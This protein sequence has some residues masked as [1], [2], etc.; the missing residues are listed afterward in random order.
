MRAVVTGAASGIG[1]ATAQQLAERGFDLV[2]VDRNA[3][4]L[5]ETAGGFSAIQHRLECV[6]LSSLGAVRDLAARLAPYPVDVLINNA[7]VLVERREQTVDGFELTF[8]VNTLAPFLLTRL[9]WP[10][11]VASGDGRVINVSSLA[12]RHG[13]INFD[14]LAGLDDFTRYGAY[15]RSK[16]SILLLTRALA[17]RAA[18]QPVAVNA[19]HPGVIGTQLGEGGCISLLL[20][21]ARPFL[22]TPDQGAAGLVYLA[23]EDAARRFRGQYLVGTRVKKTTA[24]GRDEKGSERLYKA[25][26]NLLKPWGPLPPV[27]GGAEPENQARIAP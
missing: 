13:R 3:E 15:A 2:L 18:D 8:A 24:R 9:L 16:L 14:D 10:Q 7:G 5:R 11:L 20:Q 1:R 12:Y 23:T 27:A 25:V 19:V 6:D 22:K 4:G 21:A 26:E 17:H